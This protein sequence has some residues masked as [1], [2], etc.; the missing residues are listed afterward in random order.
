MGGI[1]GRNGLGPMMMMSGMASSAMT[2]APLFLIAFAVIYLMGRAEGSRTGVRDPYLG[3][4]VAISLML[5]I[6]LQMT[7]AGTALGASMFFRYESFE[8]IYRT[9][10]P[11]VISGL[12]NAL[13]PFLVYMF[14][15]HGKGNSNV[16][17]QSFGLNAVVN[18]LVF[19]GAL[20][21]TTYMFLNDATDKNLTTGIATAAIYFMG[22]S[23]CIFPLVM[24]RA[25]DPLG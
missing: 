9:A 7:L 6:S 17:R 22:T 5:T 10:G 8:K 1:L 23:V 15:I 14:R 11:L 24:D 21:A 12:L 19:A 2:L 25:N 4:K 18:S 16:I 20:T 13:L 3:A